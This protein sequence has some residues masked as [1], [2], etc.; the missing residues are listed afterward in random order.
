MYENKAARDSMERFVWEIVAGLV[1]DPDQLRVT[2]KPHDDCLVLQVSVAP[3]DVGRVIGRGG[4]T[5]R[6]LRS[7]VTAAAGKHKLR[8][9]LVIGNGKEG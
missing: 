8:C 2:A 1:D 7:L 6:S 3:E 4:T 9:E 5:A